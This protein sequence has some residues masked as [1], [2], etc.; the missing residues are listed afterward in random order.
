MALCGGAG[1]HRRP[2][3]EGAREGV[4][5]RLEPARRLQRFASVHGQVSNLFMAAD[6]SDN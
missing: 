1:T 4:M 5:G 6:A 3:C 2:G